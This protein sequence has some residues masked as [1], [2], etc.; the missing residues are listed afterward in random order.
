MSAAGGGGEGESVALE[1]LELP[2]LRLAF[3]V[4]RGADGNPNANPNP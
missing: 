1:L 3:D 4:R 2:R